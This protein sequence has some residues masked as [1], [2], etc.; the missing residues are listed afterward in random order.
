[1]TAKQTEAAIYQALI[2]QSGEIRAAYRDTEKRYGSSPNWYKP[3]H[4][5]KTL[6]RLYARAIGPRV[7]EILRGT[8]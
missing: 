7:D 2:E 5:D 4:Y 6:A 3:G 1:M 8:E